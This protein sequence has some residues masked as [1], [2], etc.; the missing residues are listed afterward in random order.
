MMFPKLNLSKMFLLS[1]YLKNIY[2]VSRIKFVKNL[3]VV[4]DLS[5]SHV[6]TDKKKL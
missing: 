4:K 2:D 5:K 1:E 6:L 3:L